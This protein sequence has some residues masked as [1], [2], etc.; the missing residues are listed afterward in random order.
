MK[1]EIG[2]KDA[3]QKIILAV[4]EATGSLYHRKC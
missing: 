4:Q 1:I 2:V 3:D